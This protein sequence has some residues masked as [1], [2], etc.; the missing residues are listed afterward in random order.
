MFSVMGVQNIFNGNGIAVSIVGM[1][2]VFSSLMFISIFIAV[3]PHVLKLV[4]KVFPEKDEHEIKTL[5]PD[6]SIVAVIAAALYAKKF[7]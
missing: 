7:K 6:E 2:I 3:M 1:L 4:A 5:V